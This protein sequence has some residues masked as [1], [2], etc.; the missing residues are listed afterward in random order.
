MTATRMPA[1]A[2]KRRIRFDG[3]SCD[4]TM[5]AEPDND[6]AKALLAIKA[7]KLG[8]TL[9][10]A[11]MPK[12]QPNSVVAPTIVGTRLAASISIRGVM[13]RSVLICILVPPDMEREPA[14]EKHSPRNGSGGAGHVLRR[15]RVTSQQLPYLFERTPTGQWIAITNFGRVI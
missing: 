15:K 14:R 13:A 4:R 10:N 12:T 5:R 11:G 2:V 3:L 6:M 1:T 9:T 8:E 7:G